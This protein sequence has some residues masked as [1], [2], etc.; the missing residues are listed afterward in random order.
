MKLWCLFALPLMLVSARLSA[1]VPDYVK[2]PYREVV[3]AWLTGHPAYRLATID[4]CQCDEDVDDLRVGGGAW[5]PEPNYQPY[6]ASG[7][8]NRDRLPDVAFV[9]LPSH[10]DKKALI[11]VVLGAK[12]ASEVEVLEIPQPTASMMYR[13]LFVRP[14]GLLVGA[15]GSE[16]EEVPIRRKAA[17]ALKK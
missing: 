2:P 4:D 11:V 3:Q 8:F 5:K 16:A 10:A 13:G 9:A 15:F 1:E 12:V 17:R 14:A 7:D 6:Y